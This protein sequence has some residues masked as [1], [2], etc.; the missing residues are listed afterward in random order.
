MRRAPSR[1]NSSRSSL[2][3]SCSACSEATILN[4]R[5]TSLIGGVTAAGLQQPG[6]Y[7]ALL[8]HS[9]PQ[10]PTIA[11]PRRQPQSVLPAQRCRVLQGP[12]QSSDDRAD[13]TGAD[14]AA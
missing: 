2:S 10:L 14:T 8:T 4:T 7:A 6:G 1:T 9:H 13:V 11:L 12:A 3:A 5:R